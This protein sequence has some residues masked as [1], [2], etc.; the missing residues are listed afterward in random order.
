MNEKQKISVVRP[1]EIVLMRT[2]DE[3]VKPGA[4][5]GK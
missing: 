5:D 4:D 2:Q 1:D 3:L